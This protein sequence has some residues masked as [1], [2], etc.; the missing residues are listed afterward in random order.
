MN[1]KLKQILRWLAVVPGALLGAIIVMFLVHWLAMYLHHFGTADPM[2]T[3]EQGRSLFQ[4]M[5]LE[6]LER[7]GDA[8]FLVGTLI[9]VGAFIAPRFH[10][11]TAIALTLIFVGLMGWVLLNAKSIGLHLDDSPFSMVIKVIFWLTS[12]AL[13]LFYARGLDKET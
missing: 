6:S 4:S 5:S 13:A 3:D 10:F 11:A 8:V 2:I 12:I 9:G 7:F 1:I